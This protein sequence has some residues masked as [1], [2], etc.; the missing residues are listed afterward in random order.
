MQLDNIIDEQLPVFCIC[1]KDI[2]TIGMTFTNERNYTN[3]Y[4]SELLRQK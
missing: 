1:W 2:Y 3:A 4:I